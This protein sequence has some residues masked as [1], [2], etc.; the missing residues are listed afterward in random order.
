VRILLDYR[1][2]L[3]QRSGV[4]EYVHQ[5]ARSLAIQRVDRSTERRA[6]DRRASTN[7][8]DV[9]VFTSSWRDRPSRG[10]VADLEPATVVDR[11][12]PVQLLNF[13]WHRL[14]WPPVEW[15]TG[16]S[17]DVVHS[18]HP[19][20]LP[21]RRAARVV[22][23]HDLDFLRNFDR[24]TAE[25]RRDYPGLVARHAHLADGIVVVSHHVA[26]LVTEHLGV[27]AERI[28]VCPNGGPRW[29]SEGD[30]VP[31]GNAG[32]RYLLF[33]GTLEPRKNV[34]GL[35]AAYAQL[36]ADHPDTPPLVLAGGR[37]PA[38]QEWLDAIAR[39]PLAGRV[40]YRGY[41]E[42]RARRAVY[43]GARMLVLPSFDEG[44]GLT[45]VE[46]MSLGVP[47]VASNRGAIP[48]VA[49]GAALLVD[50]DDHL[51][52]AHA[53]DRVLHEP[54]LAPRLGED[55]LQRARAFSWTQ[56]AALTRTAYER[57]IEARNRR[58]HP[59]NDE[60]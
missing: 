51:G 27:P 40:E 38:A 13:A 47:V 29:A 8:D 33:V 6:G 19:L 24:T 44:F 1:P 54:G 23:I 12:F 26:R 22:T 46:A 55:G 20:L 34:S 28:S 15:L 50:P 21:S 37:T 9:E 18:P 42:D 11:R 56:T 10:A 3:R 45:V 31:P 30:P 32:G 43:A 5:L 58:I 7:F 41:V 60:V 14:L 25:I 2:A 49:G 59:A 48:E 16:R 53:M 17:Y 35:L 39:P 57:A 52:L 36:C 4:G